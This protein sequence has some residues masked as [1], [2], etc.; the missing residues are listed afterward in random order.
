MKE[1]SSNN[2]LFKAFPKILLSSYQYS[3]GST[4]EGVLNVFKRARRILK[5]LKKE[6]NKNYMSVVF[7]DKM[8]LAEHSPNNLLKIILSQLEY[9]LN[10][11]NRKIAFVGISNRSLDASKMNRGI[12]LS[13]PEPE[14]DDLKITSYTIGESYDETLAKENKELY[15]NLGLGYYKYKSFLK[16]EHNLDGKDE[17]HGNRDFYHLV[18]HIARNITNLGIKQ[19][20]KHILEIISH[21]SIERNFGGL[22]FNDLNKTTSIEKFKIIF[23]QYYENLK[24]TIKYDVKERI[25]NNINDFDSRYLLIISKSSVSISLIESI[26][27]EAKKEYC[28]YIGSQ[29]QNDLKSE[30]YSFIWNKENY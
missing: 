12:Y 1:I 15:E 11:G 8:G 16:K 9:D 22:Q 18:K 27:S 30:E 3:M 28:Y 19:I 20:D 7:F 2:I 10:E 29:F 23:S 25:N 6:N 24:I 5:R 21:E 14:E 26:L 13:I 4:S 17:F